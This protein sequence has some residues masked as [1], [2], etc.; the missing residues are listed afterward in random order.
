MC[1]G[2]A[3]WVVLGQVAWHC[4]AAGLGLCLATAR[5]GGRDMC[6]CAEQRGAWGREEGAWMFSVT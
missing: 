4:H 2:G 3:W 6:V 1:Y 5:G